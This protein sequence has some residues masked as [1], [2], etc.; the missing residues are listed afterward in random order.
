MNKTVVGTYG[1][2]GVQW[3]GS[4][5]PVRTLFSYKDL[6]QHVSPFLLFDYAGP[7]YFEPTSR[8]RGVASHPHRGFELVT[9]VYEGQVEHQDSTGIRRVFGAG[10]VQWMTAARGIRHE[11]HH[12]P[13]FMESGGQLRLVQLWINLPAK[14]KMAPSRYQFLPARSIPVVD[15]PDDAGKA[16]VIAG[17][18]QG[19]EGS[20]RTFTPINIWELRLT[21]EADTLIDIPSGQ[22]A[23]LVVITGSITVA[24][25]QPVMEAEMALLSQEGEH[26]RIETR[27]DATVLV[28]TGEPLDEPIVG[29]GR[30]VMNT[31][32][33][34]R[35][36]IADFEGGATAN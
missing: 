33:E 16:R 21:R 30:F 27:I 12:G 4:G 9:I 34:V 26:V 35:Q 13:A 6:K 15:L 14:H 20:G 29:D 31:E 2:D 32:A 18:M 24:G 5:F 23:M 28:L 25:R 7:H 22:T 3:V 11:E 1:R 36:A 8:R 19:A 10:D 17:R